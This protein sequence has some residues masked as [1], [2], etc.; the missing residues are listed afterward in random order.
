GHLPASG[1]ELRAGYE[2]GVGAADRCAHGR[3]GAAAA[4]ALEPHRERDGRA[5]TARGARAAAKLGQPLSQPSLDRCVGR[6]ARVVL[7]LVGVLAEIL[8]LLPVGREL[9][10]LEPRR[11]DA[12][13]VL[14]IGLQEQCSA[15]LEA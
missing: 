2:L 3:T 1:E 14:G 8:E 10:V 9:D 11:T 13:E 4:A 12:L 5:P 6:V 15:P 7:G